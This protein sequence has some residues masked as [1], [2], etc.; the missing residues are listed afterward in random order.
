M[1]GG[2]EYFNDY[3][4]SKSD[5]I[6]LDGF[7][8]TP[9]TNFDGMFANCIDLDTIIFD[10]S[11]VEAQPTSM[12][13]TFFNC[14]LL[15]G[16]DLKKVLTN[17]DTS[18]VTD[19]SY[20]F[21]MYSLT[22]PDE[23]D[24]YEK[25]VYSFPENWNMEQVRTLEGFFSGRNN[26][27]CIKVENMNTYNEDLEY[28]LLT[29]TSG[30]YRGCTWLDHIEFTSL[31]FEDNIAPIGFNT[32]QVTNMSYMFAD[33]KHIT[34]VAQSYDGSKSGFVVISSPS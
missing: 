14:R 27:A 6:N 9:L 17:F 13:K 5:V 4:G 12:R 7:D 24:I 15:T 30:M 1:F 22:D 20:M 21:G 28:S 29:S 34:S 11:F 16:T 8:A 3:C 31:K 23:K 10:D 32:S 18:Q 2:H 33:C 19:M 25:L 26:T